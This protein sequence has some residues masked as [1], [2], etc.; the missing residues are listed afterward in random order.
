MRPSISSK[1]ALAGTLFVASALLL[2]CDDDPATRPDSGQALD[3]VTND[4]VAINDVITHDGVMDANTGDTAHQGDLPATP[5]IKADA[6]PA[7]CT[8]FPANNPWNTDISTL[9]VHKN[10]ANFITSIGAGDSLHPDFGT[11]WAGAPNGIPYVIVPGNQT[12]VPIV[13]TAWGNQSDPG[14][15]PIPDTAPIEGGPN[16]TGD[17]HVIAVDMTSCVL[18]ELF[19]AFFQGAG[20][21]W[22]A[23]SG[24]KFDLKS[25]KLRT[26]GWTSADAAGL[27]IY[28]GL[29]RYD[30]VQS[31]AIK[32]AL[33]FTV[34]KSQKAYVLPA[35]HYASSST[36]A[37]RPP[38]GLRLRLKASVNISGYSKSNQVILKALKT[39]GMIVADNGSDW[40]LSGAPNAKW[41]DGDLNKLK[42]IKGSN[43]EVVDTGPIK[44]T[45]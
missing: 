3:A 2:A 12:K 38:M 23:S 15:F 13:Y 16:G 31:G 25:N 44:T 10:S 40:F 9:P 30:E 11:V 17:R 41:N 39:Y 7:V 24:A 45:Y 20:K 28:P 29:V 42:Q 22:K 34:S 1:S 21:G 27:P 5:D 43:F 33:R 32:H 36:D 6:K 26:I 4:G 35:T 8:V 18:Y 14:P 19:Y 37:N